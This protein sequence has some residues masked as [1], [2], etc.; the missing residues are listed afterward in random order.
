MKDILNKISKPAW[1]IP[2]GAAISVLALII[3]LISTVDEGFG[4]AETPWIVLLTLAA[5][6]LC[7]GILFLIAQKGEGFLPSLLVFLM[8]IALTFAVYLLVMGKSGV[9]GTVLFSDL[10][11]GYA[12]AER[13]C[14]L[15]VA[16]I[17]LE[18]IAALVTAAAA[19]FR[20][21]KKH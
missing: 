19:F 1:L 5:V 3:A 10:E 16:A 15:G 18:M 12:P 8:V 11:K 4:M 9:F 7:G 17:V 14:W 20:L 6:L 13:A 2:A 21:E